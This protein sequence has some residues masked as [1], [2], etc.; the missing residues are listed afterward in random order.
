MMSRK[1]AE[2]FEEK[3]REPVIEI[4]VLK[5]SGQ[6]PQLYYA[7]NWNKSIHVLQLSEGAIQCSDG[8]WIAGLYRKGSYLSKHSYYGPRV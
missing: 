1:S 4:Y 2:I 8:I 6:K 5:R 7:S 3:D